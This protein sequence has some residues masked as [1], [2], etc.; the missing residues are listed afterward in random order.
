MKKKNLLIIMCDQLRKDYLGCYG[1]SFVR[2]PN[3]DSIASKSM[4][5]NQCFVNNPICMPNRMSIFSAFGNSKIQTPNLDRLAADSVVFK[6]C[7]TPSP[8]CVPARLSMMSGQYPARTGCNNNNRE[9]VYEGKGFYSRITE[10]GYQ[11]CCVGKMHYL[12]DPYGDI[13]F[14]KRHTQEE[15]AEEGDEYMQYIRGKYPSQT[16]RRQGLSY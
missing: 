11:S 3:I 12:W 1:N 16:H 13:G 2:T 6:H 4:K 8:V 15:L 5:F 14:E 7:I 10:Q 9:K